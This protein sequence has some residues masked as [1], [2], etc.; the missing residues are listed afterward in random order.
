MF[1]SLF[2]KL[3]YPTDKQ[4]CACAGK[5][6]NQGG[7]FMMEAARDMLKSQGHDGDRNKILMVRDGFE[8][9]NRAWTLARPLQSCCSLRDSSLMVVPSA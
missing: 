9:S 1:A 2:R 3:M 5:G 7:T 4:S 8:T 6:G